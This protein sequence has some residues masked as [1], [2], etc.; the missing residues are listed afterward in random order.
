MQQVQYLNPPELPAY[1]YSN[2]VVVQGHELQAGFGVFQEVW[3]NRPNPPAI[4]VLYVVGLARP[5]FMV[6]IDTIA[7][8][9]QEAMPQEVA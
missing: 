1:G 5:E 4:S 8:V 7:V 6:E 3:G 9:P 2:V